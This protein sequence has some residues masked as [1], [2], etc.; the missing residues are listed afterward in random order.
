[1]LQGY[2]TYISAVVLLLYNVA[3]PLLGVKDFTMDQVDVAVNVLLTV[4]IVVFRKLAK[5][6]G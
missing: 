5:G 6:K 4:A 1:M 2:R 3:L